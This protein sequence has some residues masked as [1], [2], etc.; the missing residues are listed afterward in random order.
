MIRL[1][2][3]IW[4]SIEMSSIYQRVLNPILPEPGGPVE[5]GHDD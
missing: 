3:I 5:P 1:D 2:R 4:S